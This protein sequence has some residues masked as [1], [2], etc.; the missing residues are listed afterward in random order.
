MNLIGHL[1]CALRYEPAVRVGSVLPDLLPL[2]RRRPRIS[3][4]ARMWEGEISPAPEMQALLRGIR[5]HRYVDVEF[6]HGALFRGC[7]GGLLAALKEAS[8]A[9]G[10]KRFFPAHV[11]T[12][13]FFDRELM[14]HFPGLATDFNRLLEGDGNGTGADAGNLKRTSRDITSA[15][16]KIGAITERID[17][18]VKTA[19]V[20]ILPKVQT[21]ENKGPAFAPDGKRLAYLAGPPGGAKTMRITDL[22]GKIL[23]DIPLERRFGAN[24]PPKFSPDGKKLALRVYEAGEAKIMVLS[25]E[26]GT[27][28]KAFSPLEEKGYARPLGWSRDSRL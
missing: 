11:L 19:H 22:E 28:L 12:E 2:F 8:D 25:A 13:L 3:T 24:F 7:S 6:H 26:T 4:L 23:K 16:K 15:V 18:P 1:A 10:L 14:Q 5:F 17:K 21:T 9:G 20:R 27:L